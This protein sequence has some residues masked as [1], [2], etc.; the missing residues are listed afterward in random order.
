M[1]WALCWGPGTEGSLKSLLELSSEQ[2][3]RAGPG[4]MTLS[5]HVAR[6]ILAP[7]G[8]LRAGINL[9]NFLLVSARGPRDEPLGVS[10]DLCG[11]LAAE[12]GVPLELVPYANP[13]LLAD[14]A[15]KDAWDVGLIGA[16]P[17]RAA[18]IAFTAPYAEIDATY[19]VRDGS[20]LASIGD[21][22]RRGTR[23]AVSRRA[24]YCLWLEANLEEATLERTAAPGLDASRALYDDARCDALAGLRPWLID[25]ALPDAT[26]LD[27]SFTTVRQAIG[28]PKRG[29]DPAALAFLEDFVAGKVG[30]GTVGRLIA[31][32]GVAGRLAVAR[33]PLR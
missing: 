24:A 2:S 30:D 5:A 19:A 14:A 17:A 26:I 22:D 7:T 10:P 31:D 3:P 6:A 33:P 32:R 16:E 4:Q 28:V 21:V 25:Q 20:G 23:I 11:L 13:G 15:S 12:L 9:S 8:V 1:P 18:T 29:A 27:G